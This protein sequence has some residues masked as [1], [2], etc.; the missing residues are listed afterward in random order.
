MTSPLQYVPPAVRIVRTNSII[1]AFEA[2]LNKSVKPKKNA[3]YAS[4]ERLQGRQGH[5]CVHVALENPFYKQ[6]FAQATRSADLV[7]HR[8]E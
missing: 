2:F 1:V 5:M 3:S 6:V 8:I 7:R 4:L